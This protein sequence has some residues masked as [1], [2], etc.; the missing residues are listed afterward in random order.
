MNTPGHYI[1]NLA[2]LG[3]TIAPQHNT[4]IALGAILPDIPIFGL[5]IIVLSAL[6]PIGTK[7]TML[8]SLP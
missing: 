5:V 4:A 8:K 3:K 7:I 2:L 6:F 1:L